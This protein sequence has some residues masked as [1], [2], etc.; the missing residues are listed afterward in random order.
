MAVVPAC[1]VA[2]S[3]GC[4]QKAETGTLDPHGAVNRWAQKHL[5]ALQKYRRDVGQLPPSSTNLSGYL[6][7]N[8]GVLGWKGPYLPR[9]ECRGPWGEEVVLKVTEDSA[10]LQSA[11]PDE[12]WGT[13]DD[14][15]VKLPIS[16][17]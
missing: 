14:A 2:T 1:L 9:G 4:E 7:E 6:E 13:T 17:Q 15:E 3:V 5:A 8:P 10:I 16:I 11:G 12:E